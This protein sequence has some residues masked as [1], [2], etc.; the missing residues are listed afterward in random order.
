[1]KDAKSSVVKKKLDEESLKLREIAREHRQKLETQ[2]NRKKK[3]I[4][5]VLQE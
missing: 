4:F 2:D 3:S 5:Y 1:M